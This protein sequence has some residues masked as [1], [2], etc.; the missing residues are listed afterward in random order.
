VLVVLVV[1][2]M[3]LGIGGVSR[4]VVLGTVDVVEG[5][6]MLVGVGAVALGALLLVAGW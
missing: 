3:V 2:A 5:F 6:W 4:A 1:V